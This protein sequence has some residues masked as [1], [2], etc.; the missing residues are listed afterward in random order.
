MS[1]VIQPLRKICYTFMAANVQGPGFVLVADLASEIQT[2]CL[3]HYRGDGLS[4]PCKHQFTANVTKV[5]CTINTVIRH[6]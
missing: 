2:I 3:S 4:L 1:F 6:H 5:I